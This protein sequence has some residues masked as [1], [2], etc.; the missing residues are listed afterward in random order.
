MNEVLRDLTTVL[1]AIIGVAVLA[2]IV[3]RRSNTVGVV[4][5]GS[6]AF[7]TGLATAEG[8]VT[9]YN[10]GPPVYSSSFSNLFNAAEFGAG[11]GFGGG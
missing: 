3:S 10:P 1:L 7:N 8:P 2:L 9:G 6:S 4:N 5:A 11:F